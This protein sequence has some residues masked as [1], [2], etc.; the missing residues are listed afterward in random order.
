MF[1]LGDCVC[2]MAEKHVLFGCCVF[3]LFEMFHELAQYFLSYFIS[4]KNEILFQCI[5][6]GV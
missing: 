4:E 1:E 5:F 2:M 6:G 3:Y